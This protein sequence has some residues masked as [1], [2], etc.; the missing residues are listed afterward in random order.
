[1]WIKGN[2]WL[3]KSTGGDYRPLNFVGSFP[4]TDISWSS[5]RFQNIEFELPKGLGGFMLGEFP[6]WAYYYLFFLEKERSYNPKEN[7]RKKKH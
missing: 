5:E 3:L 2:C 1:L 4:V 7:I 6:A